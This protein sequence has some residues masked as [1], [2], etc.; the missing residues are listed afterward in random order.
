MFCKVCGININDNLTT[1]PNCGAVV[2]NISYPQPVQTA[3]ATAEKV[4]AVHDGIAVAS[5]VLGIV[6]ASLGIICCI[7]Y[8]TAGVSI[9]CAIVGLILG[10]FALKTK[11]KTQAII[12]LSLSAVAIVVSVIVIIVWTVLILNGNTFGDDSTVI[13]SEFGQFQQ[14]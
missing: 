7:P 3:E 12:G 1:C 8:V 4:S 6:S 9:L 13:P 14:N 2:E 11:K 5:L 10:I